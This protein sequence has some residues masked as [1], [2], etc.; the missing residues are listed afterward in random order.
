[1]LLGRILSQCTDG[2][3]TLHL[4]PLEAAELVQEVRQISRRHT[5]LLRL[6][7][8]VY[9]N[10]HRLTI[11]GRHPAIQFGRKLRTIDRVDQHET[12]GRMSRLVSL[13]GPDQ[14][15]IERE[16]RERIL[17]L[18]RLLDPVLT[19]VTKTSVQ[20][21]S[22]GIGTVTLGH[23]NNAHWM[24]PPSRRLASCHCV[25]HG[26]QPSRYGREIHSLTIYR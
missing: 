25:V 16:I 18:Y 24:P 12:S 2:H 9:L 4:Q 26:S 5:A 11:A 3:Q 13:E 6:G 15:P 20:C 17:L 22:D 21:G 19:D 10:Q 23:R 1:M 14:V 7:G 8:T